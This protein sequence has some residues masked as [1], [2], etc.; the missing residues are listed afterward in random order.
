MSGKRP[1]S[2]FHACLTHSLDGDRSVESM[3]G[4]SF[5]DFRLRSCCETHWLASTPRIL[6]L[7][8]SRGGVDRSL[9]LACVVGALN[10]HVSLRERG[11]EAWVVMWVNLSVLFPHFHV[12]KGAHNTQA[13]VTRKATS[14]FGDF[15]EMAMPTSRFMRMRPTIAFALIMGGNSEREG[16]KSTLSW[17]VGL[18]WALHRYIAPFFLG[19]IPITEWNNVLYIL[20]TVE[21]TAVGMY[22]LDE[23]LVIY[24]CNKIVLA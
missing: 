5:I 3:E 16:I 15:A 18:L 11:I 20:Q 12:G 17:N 2:L 21:I 23:M 8:R 7:S 1:R 9:A 24:M 4:R 13:P 14:W 19:P 6:V 22:S 10:W